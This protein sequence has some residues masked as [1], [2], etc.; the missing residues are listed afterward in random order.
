LTNGAYI[1]FK[2]PASVKST[3]KSFTPL[4]N[5]QYLPAY[6]GFLLAEKL[7]DY[8]Q[9][10]LTEGARMDL[11]IMKIFQALPHAEQQSILR[12]S[13]TEL[14]TLLSRNEAA[15]YIAISNERWQLNHLSFI[16]R[17]AVA[18]G[19]ITGVIAL[20]KKA[21]VHFIADYTSQPSE[22]LNLVS[23]IDLFLNE[24]LNIATNTYIEL[25]KEK[26]QDHT[27]FIEKSNRNHPWCHS[28][29]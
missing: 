23:D 1:C 27:H 21:F 25:L 7:D 28:C 26:L 12:Q 6:A 24:H 13:V 17:D 11:Q 3:D 20:R 14:F 10:T 5:L 18:A 4:N 2:H 22:I 15:N 9:F 8:C 16:E 29:F 19:D